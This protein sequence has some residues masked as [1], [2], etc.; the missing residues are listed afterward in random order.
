MWLYLLAIGLRKSMVAGDESGYRG[1]G[2]IY[3][4]YA[5]Q[6]NISYQNAQTNK[7]TSEY[8]ESGQYNKASRLKPVEGQVIHVKDSD[9]SHQGCKVPINAPKGKKWIALIQRGGCG[10][11]KK[12][13]NAVKG[14][15]SAVVVYENRNGSLPVQDSSVDMEGE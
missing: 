10:T 15:A 4:A 13:R 2:G 9:N 1:F 3:E 5:A 7:T 8:D 12:I 14:N 6:V 11:G